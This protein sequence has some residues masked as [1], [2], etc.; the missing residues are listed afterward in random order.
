[1]ETKVVVGI[2]ISQASFDVAL[3]LAEKAGYQHLKFNNPIAGFKKL[4]TQLPAASHCVME[5][6]YL[7]LAVY[8]HQQGMQVSVP[9]PLNAFPRCA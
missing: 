4:C 2:D 7:P 5:A 1:M 3:P 8:L 6:S 9:L